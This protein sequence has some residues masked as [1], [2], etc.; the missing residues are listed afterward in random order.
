LE[1]VNGG[2]GL[3]FFSFCATE[4]TCHLALL[5]AATILSADS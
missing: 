5:T 3:R 1:V 2:G 4:L